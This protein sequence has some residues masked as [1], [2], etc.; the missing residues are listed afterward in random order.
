MRINVDSRPTAPDSRIII[1]PELKERIKK[2]QNPEFVGKKLPEGLTP[3]EEERQAYLEGI[4]RRPPVDQK[5][6]ADAQKR[7]EKYK[8]HL[9]N[10]RKRIVRN[11]D[12]WRLKQWKYYEEKNR[13]T[14]NTEKEVPTAWLWN[15]IVSKLADLIEGYPE[16]NIRPKRSD[17]VKEAE[18][19]KSIIPVI[20]SA[21]EYE[22]VY[23]AVALYLLKQGTGAVG[24]FWDGNAHDGLGE[25][26]IK[27]VDLLELY[28]ESG[29]TDI[30]DSR[31][32]FHVKLEDNDI[33]FKKYPQLK[34]KLS[35]NKITT[36][37]YNTDDQIDKDNKSAVVDWWYKKIDGNG[38]SVL[39]LCQFVEGEVL[40]ATENDP[41]NFPNGFY[42]HGLYPYIIKPLFEVEN[43]ITGYGYIDIGQGDLHAIDVLTSAMLTNA[44][45]SSKPRYF[46]KNTQ[47]GIN[48]E[49][50]CDL[51]RDLVHVVGNF[52]EDNVR[53]ITPPVMPSI[54]LELREKYI[55]DLKETLG[56][57]DV[58]NGGSVS[59]VTAASA[60]ATMQEHGGKLSREHN[61]RMYAIHKEVVNM[62]IE[63]IRQFYTLPR[64]Y[65]ITGPMGKD[66]FIEYDNRGLQPQVQPNILGIEMGLRLP[67]FDIEISAQKASPYSKMEQNELAIQLYNL[68]VFQPQNVDMAMSLLETMDFSHKDE[69]MSIVSKKGTML[70]R[71]QQLQQIALQLAQEHDAIHGTNQVQLLA[72]AFM[73]ENGK[74][75]MP[76]AA[77]SL[78]ELNTDGTLKANEH[79][80]VEKA[81]INAQQSTQIE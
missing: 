42:D 34:G 81:R 25:I 65:R 15:C 56:N 4:I 20:C 46:V 41:E 33:L 76:E 35:G 77:V 31:E 18:K 5:T 21:N 71:Y 72:Q 37:E 49:E 10:L 38:N 60:I 75:P 28:W 43:E 11:E 16:A 40:F 53:Q 14:I 74:N 3:E 58:N 48:E 39:H 7:L 29:I 36:T 19:L 68:G 23:A 6:V 69:I 57:R 30:Q 70:Q 55:N 26:Q 73:A 8:S 51:N 2:Y 78:P 9:A 54:V 63:M 13:T 12:F 61:K 52:N 79:P 32:V 45:V 59:G 80:I 47:S 62:V 17:D 22:Q 24:V 1:T 67:C 27:R 64:E 66:Q 44:K 50:F